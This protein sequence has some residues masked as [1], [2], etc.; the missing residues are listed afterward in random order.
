MHWTDA[1]ILHITLNAWVI[2]LSFARFV[3]LEYVGGREQTEAEQLHVEAA[4]FNY[5]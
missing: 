2:D 5:A 4:C 1:W 3:W